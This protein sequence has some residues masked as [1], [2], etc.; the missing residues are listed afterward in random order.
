[1]GILMNQELVDAWLRMSTKSEEEHK[2]GL[3][4]ADFKY[5]E[6]LNDYILDDPDKAWSAI[7]AVTTAMTLAEQYAYIAAGPFESLLV[8]LGDDCPNF[9]D[10]TDKDTLKHLLPYVWTGGLS[11]RATEWVRVN[12]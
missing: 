8:R 10:S 2:V 6:I 4:D 1:M 3:P 9:F 7:K 5:W 11:D 12:H